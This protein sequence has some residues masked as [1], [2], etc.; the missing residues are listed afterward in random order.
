MASFDIVS[1]VDLQ[2]L[3]NAINGARKEIQTRYDF[4]GSDTTLDFDKKALKISR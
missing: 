4:K 3:D 1:K 2:T